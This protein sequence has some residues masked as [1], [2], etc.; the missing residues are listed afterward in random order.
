[1]STLKPQRTAAD[2]LVI[3]LSP[4]LIIL[5]MES[6]CAFLVLVFYRGEALGSVRWVL[7]WFTLA[8]VLVSRIGIEQGPGVAAVYGLCLAGVTWLYLLTIH[9]AYILGAVM[10]VTLWWCAH[11][12][13]WN[14]TQLEEVEETSDRGLLQTAWSKLTASKKNVGAPVATPAKGKASQEPAKK[15]KRPP[16]APGVWLI[17]FS[18]AA[19]PLFGIGETLVPVNDP[20]AHRTCFHYLV[21]YLGSALGLLLTTSF[22]GLRHYLRQRFLPMPGTIMLGWLKFGVSIAV[23]VMLLALLLP[24]PGVTTAWKSLGKQVDYNLRRASQYAISLNPHG[25]GAGHPGE[26]GQAPDGQSG[27]DKGKP[28]ADQ[29]PKPGD[30]SDATN[31]QPA[32]DASGKQ[33]GSTG[34][35]DSSGQNG[36]SPPPENQPSQSAPTTEP[37]PVAIPPGGQQVLKVLFWVVAI[38]LIG[39]WIFR[40][41]E[42]LLQM[43]RSFWDAL[44]QFFRDLLSFGGN[45]NR[46]PAP[47]TDPTTPQWQ[48]FTAYQNPFLT[49]N[50]RGWT[51]EQLILYTFE[52]LQSWSVQQGQKPAPEKTAREFCHDLTSLHPEQTDALR[53]LGFLHGHAAYA[54][55]VPPGTDVEFLRSLWQYLTAR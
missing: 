23:I 49:G 30:G 24:R 42:L 7:F 34:K 3:S 46:P 51:P 50:D 19:L 12:L 16:Q 37:P 10:L 32:T 43:A 5:L 41:R 14:C 15:K 35:P 6:L 18:L 22:L 45:W 13:T 8:V 38:G 53:Q 25:K 40:H 2:Y 20:A 33:T 9:P 28:P 17:Y 48:P 11:K 27:S 47:P 55:G 54:T 39:F 1:M 26:H 21:I 36:T 4:A 31:N 44:R 52:A 29:G